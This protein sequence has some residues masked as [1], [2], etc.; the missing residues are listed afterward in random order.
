MGLFDF[1]KGIGKKNTAPAEPQAAP[2]TPQA[3]P[4]EPSAQ[5][6]ANKL[7]GLIKSLGLGIDGLSVTYNSNT[8]TA[9]IKGQVKSQ[10]DK[11]KIVLIV[12]NIDHVAQVD[13]QMTVEVPA[14]ESKF[15][16]VKSGDNL[17]KIAKEFYGDA[18]QYPKIFEANKPMLK[19]PDEIFPGQVLRIPQ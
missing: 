12:G 11:E 10:A 19:D 5:E 8:D 4:V 7:L 9:I 1:I 16:T 13:D 17:S 14:P 6:V 18:N 15:Y 2:A 3:A